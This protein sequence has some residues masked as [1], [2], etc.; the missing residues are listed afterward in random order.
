MTVLLTTHYLDE[1]DQI[2]DKIAIIN[3]GKLVVEGSPEALK[4]EL[5]GD[6]LHIELQNTNS[7]QAI[8]RMLGEVEGIHEMVSENEILFVR[9]EKGAIILP[10]ILGILEK[11]GVHVN[12]ATVKHPSLDDVYLQYTGK[13]FNEAPERSSSS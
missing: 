13:Y 10:T 11:K 8:P 5:K 6:S 9:S 12:S 4:A 1:V 7:N 2:A 3:H